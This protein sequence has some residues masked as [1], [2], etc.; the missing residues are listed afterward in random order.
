MITEVY[1]MRTR[2]QDQN[3]RESEVPAVTSPSQQVKKTKPKKTI[4]CVALG[5]A[6]FLLLVLLI[7]LLVVLLPEPGTSCKY[8]IKLIKL[9]KPNPYI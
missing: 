4:Y 1:N 2:K 6:A 5:I 8:K 3:L 9:Y 7:V